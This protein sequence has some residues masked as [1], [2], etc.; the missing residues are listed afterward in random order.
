M[1]AD[2]DIIFEDDLARV[3]G[4]DIDS[5]YGLA[6]EKQLPFAVSMKPPRRLFVQRRDIPAWQQAR[7]QQ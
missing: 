4:I 3:L 1:K 2:D 6:R 7:G 5:V